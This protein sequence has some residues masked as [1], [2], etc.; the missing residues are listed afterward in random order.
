MQGR[1][2][3][4]ILYAG[5]PHASVFAQADLARS[6]ASDR[7]GSSVARPASPPAAPQTPMRREVERTNF[8]WI[9]LLGLHSLTAPASIRAPSMQAH[10]P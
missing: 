7:P 10:Q 6:A 4:A 2:W 5:L 8:G 3:M 1:L 9:V